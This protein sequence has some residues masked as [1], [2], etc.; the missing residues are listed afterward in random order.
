MPRT[1]CGEDL[2]L[3]C[4]LEYAQQSD[5]S[6]TADGVDYTA[7]YYK[8]DLSGGLPAVG[9]GAGYEVLS[10]DGGDAFKTPLATGHKFNGW[11]DVFLATPAQGLEDSYVYGTVTCPY[12]G[13]TLKLVYH[14]FESEQGSMDYGEEV[15]VVATLPLD[16]RITLVAKYANYEADSNAD[17]PVASDVERFW[18][19]A[20]VAF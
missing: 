16:D 11:A 14:S 15:D 1:P 20:N 12:S 19:E 7:D 6:A 17:N 8:V 13:V 4:D 3:G 9:V 18:V 2:K 5:N 10:S